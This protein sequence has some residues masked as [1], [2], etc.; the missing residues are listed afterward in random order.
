[1]ARNKPY[2]EDPLSS[3]SWMPAQADLKRGPH[4]PPAVEAGGRL[5][6]TSLL[7]AAEGLDLL[8]L[9]RRQLARSLAAFHLLGLHLVADV[10]DDLWV[11]ER[12]DVADVGEVRDA[13]DHA[14]HD[15]P[16]AR[17]R[18]V[19]DDPN[20]LRTRDLSD[21]LLDRLRHLLLDVLARFDT[22]LQRDVHLDRSS[23]QVVDDGNGGRFRDL[24]DGD[25]R[26]LE[27]LRAEPVACDVDHVVDTSEDAEVAVGRLDG[28]VAGEVGP[29]LPLLAV[30]VLAVLL[31]V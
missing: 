1:M 19:G 21:L 9:L 17:L 7:D 12:R 28:A 2:S 15:L 25:R 24:V 4:R 27:L 8:Q 5:R 18:H 11:R 13:C 23:A 6:P 26:R 14:P 10:L 16:G 22:P 3:L 20:V 30:L 29:V 31:V